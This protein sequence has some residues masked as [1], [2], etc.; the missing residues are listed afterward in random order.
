LFIAREGWRSF[1]SALAATLTSG[2]NAVGFTGLE[3][4]MPDL[5]QYAVPAFVL[6]VALEAAADAVMRRE[7]YEIKDTAAS[8]TMGVGNLLVN[9]VAKALQFSIFS[10]LHRFAIFHIGYQWWAWALVFLADDFTYYWFHRV[11]HESRFF[12]ASHVVHHSSQRYNL[13]TALRQ[14]WTGS[15]MGFVFWLWMPVA[16]FPPAMIMTMGALSLLYQFWIHTELVRSLGPLELILNTPSHHRVHH[17]ANP[18]YIDR[19]HAGTLIVWDKLFGS[20]EPEDPADAPRF[21][22]TKNIDTYNPVRIAFHE[23]VDLGRDVWSARGW[24]N[25]LLYAFGNPGWGHEVPGGMGQ[26]SFAEEQKRVRVLTP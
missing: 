6:L 21:G 1:L 2:G 19:N 16:G 4:E 13:S 14:T 23:W 9:L 12:W 8:L 11:S 25:K 7:L 3:R 15:F 24:R 17:A 22:L 18:K 20:Y 10:A 26:E 5:I